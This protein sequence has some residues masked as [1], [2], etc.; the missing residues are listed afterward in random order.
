MKKIF[1]ISG[2]ICLLFLLG[3]FQV[4][5][6]SGSDIRT[7]EDLP[8]KVVVTGAI[9]DARNNPMTGVNVLEKGTTNCDCRHSS[10][11]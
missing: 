10:S 7:S 8:Q 3:T 4:F 5:S 9:V 6:M 1:L 11:S 2:V